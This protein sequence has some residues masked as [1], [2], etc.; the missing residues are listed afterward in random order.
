MPHE[1]SLPR[2][3]EPSTGPRPKPDLSSLYYP[4]LSLKHPVYTTRT[5]SH[6]VFLSLGRLSKESVQVRGPY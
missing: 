3:Q 6:I 1:A 2:S 4:T 5:R